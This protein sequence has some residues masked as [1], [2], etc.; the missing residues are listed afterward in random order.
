MIATALFSVLALIT[1]YRDDDGRMTKW[2]KFAIAGIVLSLGFSLVLF[3]LETS[4]AK[5]AAEKAKAEADATANV[6]QNILNN[7]QTTADQQKR[8]LEETNILKAGMETALDQQRL[9][10]KKSDEIA[11]G[12]AGS[13]TTQQTVLEGNE[14]ILGRSDEIAKGMENSLMAQESVLKGNEKILSGVVS[15]VQSQGEVLN[16]TGI[17]LLAVLSKDN[18]IKSGSWWLELKGD[19]S[20]ATDVFEYLFSRIPA[21]YK[22]IAKGQ[23]YLHPYLGISE[24]VDFSYQSGKVIQSYRY[25]KNEKGFV[26][27]EINL[28]DFL[29]ERPLGFLQDEDKKDKSIFIIS[30]KTTK[31]DTNSAAIAYRDLLEKKIIGGLSLRFEK[32]FTTEAE[33]RKFLLDNNRLKPVKSWYTYGSATLHKVEFKIP[34]ELKEGFF[35]Y[36][37]N[38]FQ[39]GNVHLYLDNAAHLMIS[40]DVDIK[41]MTG[42]ESSVA[43]TFQPITN[44]EI[45]VGIREFE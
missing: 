7:A 8:S 33:L 23:L 38:N 41:A 19:S 18:P 17:N 40:C 3:I 6:L 36:W 28:P 34:A 4:K 44:P 16:K 2:G 25:S 35:N 31:E 39:K 5:T 15:T 42:N 21:E 43:I 11:I 1:K 12:L 22:S 32:E 37:R 45:T 14:R 29:D 9:N 10:L 13:L 24:Y 30:K 20:K 27:P 26:P